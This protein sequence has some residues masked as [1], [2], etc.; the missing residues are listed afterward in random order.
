[1]SLFTLHIDYNGQS[2]IVQVKASTARNAAINWAEN[3]NIKEWSG[4]GK[5]AKFELV[6]EM[7]DKENPCALIEETINVW[8]IS[9]LVR[10]RL[11]LINIV[12]TQ[13]E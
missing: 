2:T 12:K 5:K 9:A 6:E 11:F 8:C 7:K 10:S 3:I 13:N 4:I 1:M